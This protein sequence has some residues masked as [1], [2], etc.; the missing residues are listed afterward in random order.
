MP[1]TCI[2]DNDNV[3]M[4]C[5]VS[6]FSVLLVLLHMASQHH[7]T[8]PRCALPRPPIPHNIMTPP[9]I[10]P[11]RMGVRRY[12]AGISD[13]GPLASIASI[14]KMQPRSQPSTQQC[15]ASCRRSSE[16]TMQQF[17]PHCPVASV[18]VRVSSSTSAVQQLPLRNCGLS[19][20]A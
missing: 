1:G 11:Y 2:M 18:L 4:K 14:R 17:R 15:R 16:G 20:A 5:N 9:S 6:C 8:I 7:G 13:F 10:V 3:M 12:L 19:I